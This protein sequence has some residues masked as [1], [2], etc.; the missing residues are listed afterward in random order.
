M[1]W[2]GFCGQLQPSSS[3]SRC[4]KMYF[5]DRCKLC[6]LG[7]RG[8]GGETVKRLVP[9]KVLEPQA[10]RQ[11]KGLPWNIRMERSVQG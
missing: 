1:M 10:A 9:L 2:P 11:W 3:K 4:P 7:V 8:G 5:V 6:V